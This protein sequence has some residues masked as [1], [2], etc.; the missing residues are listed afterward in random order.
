MAQL[1]NIRGQLAGTWVDK[2]PP[3]VFPIFKIMGLPKDFDP[4]IQSLLAQYKRNE[5]PPDDELVE[6]LVD[7]EARRK[8]HASKTSYSTINTVARVTPLK[9]CTRE[10][11]RRPDTHD[12]ANHWDRD[13]FNASKRP[14]NFSKG[15]RPKKPNG[16]GKNRNNRPKKPFKSSK[17]AVNSVT[18][19]E[20]GVTFPEN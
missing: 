5:V 18:I 3:E 12:T 6:R 16:G 8:G 17:P 14:N 9:H 1:D 19:Q 20:E 4:T 7:D 11:C 15:N 13:K 2:I 10:G